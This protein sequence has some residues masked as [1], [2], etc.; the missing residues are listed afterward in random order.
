MIGLFLLGSILV[1]LMISTILGIKF[2]KWLGLK[3]RKRWI[4]SAVLTP[5]LI[6][7]PVIDEV[8]AYPKMYQLCKQAEKDIWYDKTAAG[9]PAKYYSTISSRENIKINNS[10][11]AHLEKWEYWLTKDGL[12]I[13]KHSVLSTSGGFLKFPAG[14]SGNHMSLIIPAECPS[15]NYLQVRL[16]MIQSELKLQRIN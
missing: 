11:V 7:L 9:K 13:I 4:A 10:I 16:Q 15:R 1:W 14:S 2:P 3:A 12:P 5:V 8:I 6:F